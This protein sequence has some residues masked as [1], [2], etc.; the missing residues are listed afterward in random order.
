MLILYDIITFSFFFLLMKTDMTAEHCWDG[1]DSPVQTKW[2]K[3][4]RERMDGRVAVLFV[5]LL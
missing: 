2:E 4:I 3:R 5:C 1:S